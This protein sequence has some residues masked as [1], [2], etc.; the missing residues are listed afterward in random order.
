MPYHA[1]CSNTAKALISKEAFLLLPNLLFLQKTLS[2]KQTTTITKWWVFE[3]DVGVTFGKVNQFVLNRIK[4]TQTGLMHACSVSKSCPTL[5]NPMNC[6][7]PGSSVH[8]ILQARI[9]KWDAISFSWGSSHPRNRIQVL[10]FLQWQVVSL[11]LA[12]PGKPIHMY[13][14]IHILWLYQSIASFIYCDFA[15]IFGSNS[16]SWFIIALF[17]PKCIY[18]CSFARVE[19]CTQSGQNSWVKEHRMLGNCS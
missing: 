17:H 5:C 10:C 14:H 13:L 9:L 2:R 1:C 12:P 8:G 3:Y 15:Y 11:L 6:S 19:V 4:E 18:Y 16:K 7:P